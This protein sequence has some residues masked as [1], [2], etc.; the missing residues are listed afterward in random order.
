MVVDH[1]DPV[2]IDA[3]EGVE[4]RHVSAGLL[5]EHS[6]KPE[7]RPFA[8]LTLHSDF[9]AHHLAELLGDDHPQSRAAVLAGSGTVHL[10]KRR[11]ENRDSIF[12]DTD[13]GRI[14][15]A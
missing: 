11:E 5:L 3:V 14:D 4:Q 6:G 15:V 12:W 8:F 2:F 13:G 1:E 7:C 9:P 10:C